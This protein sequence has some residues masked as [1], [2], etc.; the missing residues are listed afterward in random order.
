[1]LTLPEKNW[2]DWI[3]TKGEKMYVSFIFPDIQYLFGASKLIDFL[4]SSVSYWS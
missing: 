4:T 2:V 3:S 1:M